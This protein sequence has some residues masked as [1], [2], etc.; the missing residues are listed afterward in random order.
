MIARVPRPPEIVLASQN[1]GKLAE[2]RA[3]L[4]GR[5]WRVLGLAELDVPEA[6]DETGATF[7]DNAVLKARYY[8]ARTGRLVVADDSGLCVDA[9]GGAPGVLS[10]RFGG[11]GLDDAGRNALLLEKLRGVPGAERTARFT[12]ALA[13]VRDERVLFEA[14]E[15][16]EGRVAAAPSGE[17]GFGYDPVFFHPEYGTTLASV[18]LEEKARVSHRG[19]AFRRLVEFLDRADAGSLA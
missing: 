3:L 7:R 19:K 15:S 6:P 13:L 18:S 8:A 9:L 5:P 1:A 14:L 4:A 17:R 16:C 2:M 12:C 10:S 11:E